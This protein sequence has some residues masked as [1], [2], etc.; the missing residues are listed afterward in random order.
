MAKFIIA[1]GNK[2]TGTKGLMGVLRI[3]NEVKP[4]QKANE[5]S[6]LFPTRIATRA[7]SFSVVEARDLDDLI[8]KYGPEI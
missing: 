8:A 4:R 3:D 5:V 7:A 6:K 1:R 2:R